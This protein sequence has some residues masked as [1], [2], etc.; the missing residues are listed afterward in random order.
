[1]ITLSAWLRRY[2]EPCTAAEGLTRKG[3]TFRLTAANGDCAVLEF[4]EF[5]VDPARTVFEV[6]VAVV[7]ATAWAW[8]YRAAERPPLPSGAG[9][10]IDWRVPPPE[11]VAW[12]PGEAACEAMWA[13]GGPVHLHHTGEEL[14]ELL[15]TETVPA[16]R[17]LLDRRALEAELEHPGF[18]FSSRRPP[19]WARVLL[20]VD[21]ASPAELEGLLAEV[22]THYPVVDEF[23]AWARERAGNRPHI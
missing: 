1:M 15:R 8:T 11:H 19:G 20:R 7:P 9:A 21:D 17:R 5:R 18:A 2:V 3:L 6:R 12:A 14:V 10:L 13:Y 16:M 23:V 22:E 4:Q